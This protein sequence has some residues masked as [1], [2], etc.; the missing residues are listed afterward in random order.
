[1]V[2]SANAQQPMPNERSPRSMLRAPSLFQEILEL[3][4]W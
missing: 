1:V 4:T 2:N 3:S